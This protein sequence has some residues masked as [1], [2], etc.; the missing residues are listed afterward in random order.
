[1]RENFNGREIMNENSTSTAAAAKFPSPAWKGKKE[2]GAYGNYGKSV[3]VQ[4]VIKT[5]EEKKC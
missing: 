5:R 1:M 4:E 3:K 2:S